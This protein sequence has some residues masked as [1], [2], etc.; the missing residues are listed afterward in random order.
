[1]SGKP[2][3]ALR[4]T[5]HYWPEKGQPASAEYLRFCYK[6]KAPCD[7]VEDKDMSVTM[8]AAYR[9]HLPL[10]QEL[11]KPPGELGYG[12]VDNIVKSAGE[13]SSSQSLLLLL[14]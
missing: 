6:E 5:F 9:G 14:F 4:T 12:G 1:M 8:M 13:S 3:L 11:L 7:C 10:L 2:P